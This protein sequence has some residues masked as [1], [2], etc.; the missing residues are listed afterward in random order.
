MTWLEPTIGF[1]IVLGMIFIALLLEKDFQDQVET[2]IGLVIG[3]C[4]VFTLMLMFYW[5]CVFFG[6]SVLYLVRHL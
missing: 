1:F 5:V 3:G 2:V 4:F 6:A